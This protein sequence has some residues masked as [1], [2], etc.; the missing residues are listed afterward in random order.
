MFIEVDK[1]VSELEAP[2]AGKKPLE[3]KTYVPILVSDCVKVFSK[4]NRDS[5]LPHTIVGRWLLGHSYGA[6]LALLFKR[7]VF[8]NYP[9]SATSDEY[10]NG[11]NSR[12]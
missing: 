9:V 10:Y 12:V 3:I 7:W 1:F 4:F 6:E 2:T 5:E 8:D 11:A